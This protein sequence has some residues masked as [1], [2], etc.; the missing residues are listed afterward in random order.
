MSAVPHTAN[1]HDFSCDE[2]Q[3]LLGASRSQRPA[4]TAALLPSGSAKS[5]PVWVLTFDPDNPA[6]L[7]HRNRSFTVPDLK[8]L[9]DLGSCRRSKNRSQA[10][11]WML[12]STSLARPLITELEQV[13]CLGLQLP[14]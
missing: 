10:G 7:R 1:T 2:V 14:T 12:L 3:R 4:P 9:L 11:I 8:Q 13:A 5:V 6:I